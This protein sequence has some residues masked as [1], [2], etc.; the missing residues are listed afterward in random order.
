M[1]RAYKTRKFLSVVEQNAVWAQRRK[2][3]TSFEIAKDLVTTRPVVAMLIGR[4]GGV[5]PRP[6]RRAAWTLTLEEREE[7]SRGVAANEGVRAIARRL[8]RDPSTISRELQRYGGKTSYRAS[9]ADAQAWDRARRP[10]RCRLQQYPRLRAA[11]TRKLCTEWSP[12]QIAA[13]LKRTYPTDGT[14]HVSHETIYQTLYIQARGALKQELSAH[15]R[16]RRR[17]RQSR[18]ALQ[19][20]STHGQL[21]DTI[22]ISERPPSVADRAVPGHWEGDLL[23]GHRQSQIATLVERQS[24]FVLLVRLPR[25]D[26]TTVAR[27]LAR[28]IQRLPVSLKQSLTWDRGKEM[29]QHK[30]F[31]VATDVQVYFC[32]PHSPWQ[33]GS[34][35]NTNGLLRQ[36]FPKG[37]DLTTVTQRQL[38]AVARKLNGRPRETLG[39]TTP[40]E[41]LAATVASTV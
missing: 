17:V 41:A 5:A 13:W 4:R 27:A 15:L 6:R 12:Q 36:Y 14:M 3:A 29:A 9:L 1:A 16:R 7:I 30:A 23:I 8:G 18:A 35:E 20:G 10:K 22:A 31:T 2:G 39:W 33:R 21:A 37:M 26:S 32:D 11:V 28:R 40:A 25:R 19:R 24:R 38:D 34:N